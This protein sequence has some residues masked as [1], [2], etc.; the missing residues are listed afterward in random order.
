MAACVLFLWK[1]T[2]ANICVFNYKFEGTYD[3]LE[4]YSPMSAFEFIFDLEWFG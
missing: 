1:I 2:G 4:L 3:S